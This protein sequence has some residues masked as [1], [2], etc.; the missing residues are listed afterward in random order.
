[1][2]KL[3]GG[4]WTKV[5]HIKD[6]NIRQGLDAGAYNYDLTAGTDAYTYLLELTN[7]DLDYLVNGIKLRDLIEDFQFVRAEINSEVIASGLVIVSDKTP[8]PGSRHAPKYD[9]V[10]PTALETEEKLFSFT[11]L[12]CYCQT[13][14]K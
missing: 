9:G 11:L 7:H 2:Y 13:D 10:A 12:T 8:S 6:Q 3:K 1:M 14:R 4:N 5:Y